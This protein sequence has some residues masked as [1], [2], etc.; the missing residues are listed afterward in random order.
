MRFFHSPLCLSSLSSSIPL[1]VP[2]IFPCTSV[3]ST[4]RVR[5]FYGYSLHSCST[6][7]YTSPVVH[8]SS[9][10]SQV[11]IHRIMAHSMYLTSSGHFGLLGFT[12]TIDSEILHLTDGL[13]MTWTREARRWNTMFSGEYLL[14][15][16][17]YLS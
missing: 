6:R 14:D 3:Q 9:D 2:F 12:V 11:V 10:P 8:C 17:H 16:E 7:T 4:R 15:T 5:E 1:L 13:G